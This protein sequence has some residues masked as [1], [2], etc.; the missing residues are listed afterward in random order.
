[1]EKGDGCKKMNAKGKAFA[2]KNF[3]EAA[4]LAAV[5]KLAQVEWM[6]VDENQSFK[7]RGINRLNKFDRVIFFVDAEELRI[8]LEF[9]QVD[10]KDAEKYKSWR[11]IS[12]V[13]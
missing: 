5:W 7:L 4:I 13:S 12:A 10:V 2:V 3:K 9:I 8:I 6:F 1:M 11:N